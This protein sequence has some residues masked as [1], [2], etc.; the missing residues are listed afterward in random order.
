MNYEIV[1]LE[2]RRIIGSA[3][4]TANNAPD[5][6]QKIGDLWCKYMQEDCGILN[7]AE[8]AIVY[9]I[10]TNYN[11]SDM[12]YDLVVGCEGE[13]CPESFTEIVIPAGKYAKFSFHGHVHHD[14][15]KAWDEIWKTELSRAY[16]ADFEEYLYCDDNMEGDINIYVG[17][18][19]IC[20]SCGMP[21]TT[22]EQY[23]TEKNSAKN[24]DYCCYCYKDGAFTADCSMEEM[25]DFCLNIP[26][27]ASLYTDKEKA[28]AQMM[29]FYPSLKRW[30]K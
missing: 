1:T 19:D 22:D 9:G 5:M 28:K 13:T 2:E 8:D 27:S 16:I 10:Y 21:M 29:E 12:S 6:Q 14:V 30:K 24:K 23:S 26:E 18:A 17:L 7:P 4:R 15:A 11:Y 25:I 3:T 20:Q